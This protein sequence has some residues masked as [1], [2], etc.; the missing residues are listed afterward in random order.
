MDA[1]R[2]LTGVWVRAARRFHRRAAAPLLW[3][4]LP[5]DCF[6]C[7]RPL[8]GWQ[9]LGACLSCWTS[10]RTLEPP[11]CPGCGLPRPPG[12]DL[13]GPAGGRCSS[14][15]LRP[16][17]GGPVRAAV[18]YDEHARAFLLRAKLGRRPELLEP[19]G[20]HLAT[21][22]ERDGFAGA[23][24]SVVPVPSHPWTGLR[25]GFHPAV[26]IARPVARRLALALDLGLLARGWARHAPVKGLTAAGRR[27]Q[28]AR[29]FRVRGSAAGRRLVLVDDVMT[30]GAT[31]GACAAVLL[32]AG[33]VEVRI[34]SWARTLPSAGPIPRL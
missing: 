5:S 15:V 9:R 33:A 7:R 21:V 10:F 22:L 6:A 30:T 24:F 8:R 19:L 16:P 14:C 12:T 27:R 29:A 32:G 13:M 26:E 20:E 28:V 3:C 23:G 17:P 4:L 11:L 18:P 34:A 2:Y 1:N 25:R 31:A